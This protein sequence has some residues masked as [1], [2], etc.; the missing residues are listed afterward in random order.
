MFHNS[1]SLLLLLL[2]PQ[3]EK[4]FLGYVRRETM[5]GKFRKNSLSFVDLVCYCRRLCV[6]VGEREDDSN[7]SKGKKKGLTAV[8]KTTCR[9]P[10]QIDGM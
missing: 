4:K 8:S 5:K 2:L 3:Q 7:A 10:K 1:K 9:N 6:S